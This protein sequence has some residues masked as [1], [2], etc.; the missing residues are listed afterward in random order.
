MLKWFVRAAFSG[1]VVW[2]LLR[3]IPLSEVI[4]AI[5]QESLCV[6]VLTL[7]ITAGG[8]LLNAMKL[9]LLLGDN[10]RHV[11]VACVR[12]QYVGLVA[13]LGLPGLAGGDFVR[14][15]Y[16]APIVGLRRVTVASITD[17]IIDTLTNLLFVAIALP[18]AGLP[19]PVAVILREAEIWIAG[20]IAVGIAVAI[21]LGL[22]FMRSRRSALGRLWQTFLDLAS[23]RKELATAIAISIL[24]QGSFVMTNAWVAREVGVTTGLAAWYVAWP[25]SKLVAVLPISLGGIGVREAALVLILSPYGAP[26]EAVLAS[27]ILWQSFFV[28]MGILGFVVAQ[29]VPQPSAVPETPVVPEATLRPKP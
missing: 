12:A 11:T 1:T 29:L 6:L 8:H 5:R 9:R 7:A 14:A 2:L 27:G 3:H 20:G 13:N 16:L 24:V 23:R 21:G 18:F 22:F 26:R 19:E 28:V 10:R 17:R 4:A 25:L 15:A